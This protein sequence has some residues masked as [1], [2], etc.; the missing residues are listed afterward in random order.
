M[1]LAALVLASCDSDAPSSHNAVSDTTFAD[2]TDGPAPQVQAGDKD[3]APKPDPLDPL[4]ADTVLSTTQPGKTIDAEAAD[5]RSRELAKVDEAAADEDAPDKLDIEREAA[6]LRQQKLDAVEK[7]LAA[8]RAEKLKQ[9]GDEIAAYTLAA[10][11]KA[12]L[13]ALNN[14]AGIFKAKGLD[15]AA[16]ALYAPPD[17]EVK[18]TA[19]AVQIIE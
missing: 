12:K 14:A 10:T 6:A 9:V 15:E 17:H 5:Y 2:T 16:Y 3:I 1:L 13:D 7:D 11:E 4:P 18:D 19:G 8:I